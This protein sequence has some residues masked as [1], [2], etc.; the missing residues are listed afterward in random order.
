[1]SGSPDLET[2]NPVP[3]RVHGDPRG[4]LW[5]ALA[6]S[7][8]GGAVAF[9]EL[10]LVFFQP[11]AVR[12]NHYHRA[13]TEWFLAVQ[14][15]IRCRLASQDGLERKECLLQRAHPA[16]LR[17][18]PGVAHQLQAEGDVEAI[19]LAVA[20]REYD[21]DAPDTVPFTF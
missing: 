3:I 2:I 15:R 11:E 20:D 1:M 13:T 4:A 19:L 16:V 7:G 8:T 21:P 9:G 18:P 10:Y 5:K 14:G 12:G 6:A 17:I